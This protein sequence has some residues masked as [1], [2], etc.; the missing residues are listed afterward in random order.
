MDTRGASDLLGFA[1]GDASPDRIG[2]RL[3]LLGLAAIPLVG[4]AQPSEAQNA[5]PKKPKKPRKRRKGEKPPLKSVTW[6]GTAKIY[7]GDKG[8]IDIGVSTMVEPFV[9]A[10]SDS[11]LISDGPTKRR[12]LF[13]EPGESYTVRDGKREDLPA[14]QGQHERQQYGAYGYMLGMGSELSRGPGTRRLQ[15]PGYPA[16]DL[17]YEGDRL[18]VIEMVVDPPRVGPKLAQRFTL[19][20]EHVSGDIRWPQ[21]IAILQNLSPYFELSIARFEAI[22]EA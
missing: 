22:Y 9:R 20:G 8:I 5:R 15:Q 6:E 21:K 14:Q 19:T 1:V 18:A 4:L 11:W 2:R 13:V 16:A 10:R 12:T 17:F 7:F 3:L